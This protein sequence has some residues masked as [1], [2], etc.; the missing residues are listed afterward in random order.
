[1][2]R[3]TPLEHRELHRKL[4]T[5][6]WSDPWKQGRKHYFVSKNGRDMKIPNPHGPTID[7]PGLVKDILNRFGITVQDWLKA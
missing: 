2:S 1:M 3:L 7:D 6:G 5:F 4:K